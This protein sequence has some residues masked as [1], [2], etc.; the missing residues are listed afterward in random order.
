M[1]RR[2]ELQQRLAGAQEALEGVQKEQRKME[3][4]S[5]GWG[6][7]DRPT[8]TNKGRMGRVRVAAGTY[9]YLEG[10]H[11]AHEVHAAHASSPP[12]N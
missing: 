9:Y 5:D 10:W 1:T 8:W 7:V 6:G 11:N 2:D 3:K 12:C 4:A